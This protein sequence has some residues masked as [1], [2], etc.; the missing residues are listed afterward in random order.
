MNSLLQPQFV[1]DG[2]AIPRKRMVE[3]LREHYAIKDERVLAAMLA[4]P[5]HLFI[6]EALRPKAY[7]DHALPIAAGQTIS[8]PFIVAKMT[9]LLELTPK[10][11]VLEI[12]FGS[13][14][15]TVVLSL[16]AREVFA[17]E[18]QQE[19][20]D[21]T[22]E[23]LRRLGVRNVYLR[24]ADGTRGWEAGAPF[25]AILVAAGGPEIPDPLLY[26]LAVGGRLV[27]PVG[28][29]RESQVLTRVIRSD[30]DKFIYE[31][32]GSCAFVP[33]IGKHGWEK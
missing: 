31:E 28:H 10:S 11:R 2:Y 19:L 25:D 1:N 23:R 33:L 22:E 21:E 12:G 26:Q 30:E 29:S 18:R 27:I 4:A 6:P 7:G 13:G 17:V 8:Q 14:Y 9:E 24:C 15:Q 32:H 20:A 3:R 5:R 16:L